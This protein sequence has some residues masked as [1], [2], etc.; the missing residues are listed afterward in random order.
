MTL[1][2]A[3]EARLRC[4]YP[5]F[6]V[7]LRRVYEDVLKLTG[8]PMRLTDGIRDLKR[9]EAI[10]AQ[11]RTTPGP[12]ITSSRPGE[13]LHH[14]GCA[15]DSCFRGSDPFL[16]S[17]AKKDPR[18]AESV[19][20]TLGRMARGHG[21]EW[22]GDWRKPVDRPHCQIRYGFTSQDIREMHREGGLKAVWAEFDRVRGVAPGQEWGQI[23]SRVKILEFPT[24]LT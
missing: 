9:Q 15:A 22:G 14:Y 20:D 19:W 16:S 1:D 24:S 13:S 3:S 2:S 6:A 17:L 7:R 12:L 5:D 10:Y 4:L 21:L 18:E 8:R 11:G 23:S